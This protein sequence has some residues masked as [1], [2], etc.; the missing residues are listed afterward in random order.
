M[1]LAESVPVLIVQH[2]VH[3]HMQEVHRVPDSALDA[4]DAACPCWEC[5][6]L[7][8]GKLKYIQVARGMR[9]QKLAA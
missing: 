9:I 5:L 6:L 3:T 7:S 2:C 4:L 1:Q 8:R